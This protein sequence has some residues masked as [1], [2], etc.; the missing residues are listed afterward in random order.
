MIV[1]VVVA[2]DILCQVHILGLVTLLVRMEEEC[3]AS[4]S[5]SVVIQEKQWLSVVLF[6]VLDCKDCN[7]LTIYPET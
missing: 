3:V 5:S 4:R 2:V 1:G 7:S 6:V